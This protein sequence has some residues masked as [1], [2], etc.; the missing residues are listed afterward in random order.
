M[1]NDFLGVSI[2]KGK[3]KMSH[4][5]PIANRIKCKLASWKCSII[6]IM[7]RMQLVNSIINNMLL[8]SFHIYVWPV[9]LHKST[10]RWI[11]NFVSSG[12][13]Y[14]KKIV[15]VAWKKCCLPTAEGGLGLR[16]IKAI[17]SSALL[18]PSWTI[19]SSNEAWVVFL[20]GRF[21]R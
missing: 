16:A 7:G 3:P 8:Y 2:L 11:R 12:N 6:F 17:N 20:K 1:C 14:I 18:K 5:Q 9:A 15:I 13:I 10:D 19:V 21:I 4:L